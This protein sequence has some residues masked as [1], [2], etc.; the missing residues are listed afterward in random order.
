MSRLNR[1]IVLASRIGGPLVER[2]RRD[3][4]GRVAADAG[5]RLQ[6][7]DAL[8]KLAAVLGDDLLGRRV[9]L[10]SAAVVAQAF[11]QP[12]HFCFVGRRQPAHVRE[13]LERTA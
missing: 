4:P 3:R 1:R 9:Q 12:Q 6:F 2:D 13:T 11:P 8:R 7:V 10:P 5:Q